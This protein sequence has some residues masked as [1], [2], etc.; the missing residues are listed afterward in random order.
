MLC[1]RL[2]TGQRITDAGERVSGRKPEGDSEQ[3][4]HDHQPQSVDDH[5]LPTLRCGRCLIHDGRS[6]IGVE[7][8]REV[9]D[10]YE[11]DNPVQD[12]DK[13]MFHDVS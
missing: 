9:E 8:N 12:S 2:G 7:V 5:L 10:G 1:V 11:N 13:Q 6:E 3:R 4:E